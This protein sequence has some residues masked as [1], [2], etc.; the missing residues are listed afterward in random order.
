MALVLTSNVGEV[1]GNNP[2]G[3]GQNLPF[4]YHNYLSQ[5]LELEPDSEVAVQ[6]VK[7]VK[8]GNVSL[9]R[10][11]NTFYVFTG[12]NGS[13]SQSDSNQEMSF[14]TGVPRLTFMN[15]DKRQTLNV[16]NMAEKIQQ[17]LEYSICDPCL[18]PSQIN[19]SGIE[20]DT[21]R[22]AGGAFEGFDISFNYSVS[23]SNTDVK[24][25]RDALFHNLF[26]EIDAFGQ[27]LPSAN[28]FFKH[29]YDKSSGILKT[30]YTQDEQMG[31]IGKE[32]M[33]RVGGELVVSFKD[34]YNSDSD[35]NANTGDWTSWAIGLSRYVD[36]ET[37]EGNGYPDYVDVTPTHYIGNE[38][39]NDVPFY[40]YVVK[41]VYDDDVS[42]WFLRLYHTILEATE[43]LPDG[44]QGISEEEFE[45]W[46]VGPASGSLSGPIEIFQTN[47]SYGAKLPS[48]VTFKIDNERVSV[49][50]TSSDGSVSYT[51]ANGS[52]AVKSHNLKP[53][54]LNT[55]CLYPRFM[56]SNQNLY[57]ADDNGEKAEF[58][59]SKYNGI[60]VESQ[61]SYIDQ[62]DEDSI[63]DR[64]TYDW[65]ARQIHYANESG[66][67]K[68]IDTRYM[69]DF[70]NTTGGPLG[71]G[72][73]TQLGL[74]GS[75]TINASVVLITAPDLHFQPTTGANAQELLGF[76]R[77]PIPAPST[78]TA[79][80][81]KFTSSGVP[82]LISK[83]SLFIRLDNFNSQSYN[84][85]MSGPSKILYHMPRF[86]T[87]GLEVGALFY[88]PNERTYIR[89]NN[90]TKLAINDFDL[91]LVNANDTLA[92]NITGKT[93]IMLHFRKSRM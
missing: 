93:I 75:N 71:N 12:K 78:E 64:L 58:V 36:V 63:E 41:S 88:E 53:I 49:I 77:N 76:E 83:D 39:G 85:Q 74:N 13:E 3:S 4:Q 68:E 82:K 69:F 57:E 46:T 20:V 9:D 26:N 16:E 87:S 17:G 30:A 34:A 80:L 42:K 40:D 37:D 35:N 67:A 10:S 90:T 43:R 14:T 65:Y 45:Y 70:T 38:D 47:A 28:T 19:T 91:S 84:G 7:V 8:N 11:N 23:G 5:P 22:T 62:L 66:Q 29:T 51:L 27:I 89:L 73:Y 55:Y 61:T 25:S 72:S 21:K 60:I 33:S 48:E 54:S 6:S 86:D 24:G 59:I 52:Q 31:V 44:S 18:L 56:M 81:K 15:S 2:L 50:A 92:D 1:D 79:L 32:P